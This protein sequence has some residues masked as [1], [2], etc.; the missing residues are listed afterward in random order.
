[1]GFFIGLMLTVQVVACLFMILIV[2]MQPS[3]A[4][5]GLGA[6]FGSGATDTLFGARTGNILTKA[7]VWLA[8]ILFINSVLLGY[9]FSRQSS[10]V[11]DAVKNAPP[12]AVQKAEPA[13]KDKK[14]AAPATESKAA[15]PGK[16]AEPAKTPAPAP[17]K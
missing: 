3:K 12:A 16:P 14:A 8:A 7:T 10:A 4:D 15:A 17:A 6:A 2:L 1:M 9:L 13:A 11:L 5:G